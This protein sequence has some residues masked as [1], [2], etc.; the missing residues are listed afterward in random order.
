MFHTCGVPFHLDDAFGVLVDLPR[1]E[2]AYPDGHLDGR[3]GGAGA[4]VFRLRA[5][6]RSP[7]TGSQERQLSRRR[8]LLRRWKTQIEHCSDFDSLPSLVSLPICKT[9]LLVYMRIN[10]KIK[11]CSIFEE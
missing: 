3:H 4:W 2:G 6:F 7:S 9:P 1:V 5:D 8:E 10:T 11:H